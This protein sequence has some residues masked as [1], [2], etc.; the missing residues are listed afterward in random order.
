MNWRSSS[1]RVIRP[2][3]G[4][5]DS[6]AEPTDP[7]NLD[8]ISRGRSGSPARPYDQEHLVAGEQPFGRWLRYH[9]Y[10]PE[11][12]P[13]DKLLISF[14]SARP[15]TEPRHAFPGPIASQGRAVLFIRCL[16]GYWFGFNRKPVVFEESVALVDS[17][18]AERSLDRRDTIACGS[19][20]GGKAAL[21]VAARCGL[22]QAVVG[23]PTIQ[24]GAFLI[25]KRGP[26]DDIQ[27]RM[28]ETMAG[29]IDKSARE[30]LDRWA[31]EILTEP[32]P[33]LLIRLFTS[34]EDQLYRTQIKTLVKLCRK[35]ERLRLEL[36]LD[37]YHLHRELH[38]RMPAYLAKTLSEVL[39]E[40]ANRDAP[41]RRAAVRGSNR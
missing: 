8:P 30:F 35:S 31:I 23:T 37:D 15:D 36:T 22:G 25:G 12:D 28:A 9:L 33:D 3:S 32:G 5:R 4:R 21:L 41:A 7:T 16:D 6:R 1:R 39:G 20:V 38:G 17:M 29:G 14:S 19:S 2:L 18:I 13:G 40:S 11:G 10:L 27:R 26:R 24:Q 34:R